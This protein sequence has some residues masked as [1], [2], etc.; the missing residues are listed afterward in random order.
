MSVGTRISFFFV[1]LAAVVLQLTGCSLDNVGTVRDQPNKISPYDVDFD[2][3]SFSYNREKSQD[4][5]NPEEEQ[6]LNDAQSAYDGGL[7]TL[8]REKWSRL[9]DDYPTSFYVPF[10]ELKIADSYFLGGDHAQAVSSY[11]EFIN[12]HPGHEAIPYVQLQIGRAYRAQYSGAKRDITPIKN[13]LK[14]L[15]VLT[16]NFPQSEYAAEGWRLTVECRELIAQFEFEVAL[17]YERRDKTESARARFSDLL[18]NYGDTNVV[19][20]NYDVISRHFDREPD[21]VA[22][23]DK[24]I[25]K[26]AS[27]SPPSAPNILL[28]LNQ[29]ETPDPTAGNRAAR[30]SLRTP[31]TRL[32]GGAA[33]V[34]PTE[35]IINLTCGESSSTQFVSVIPSNTQS[36]LTVSSTEENS[37]T[38]CPASGGA[39]GNAEKVRQTCDIGQLKFNLETAGSNGCV[40]VSLRSDTEGSKPT[41]ISTTRPNRVVIIFPKT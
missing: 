14:S 12:L 13:A 33:P 1:V 30:A 41:V 36:K 22:A 11:Q 32:S 40:N 20:Q 39:E 29:P 17:F 10:V 8:A 31:P 18:A 7:Y 21:V 9:K 27:F 25:K 37:W 34:T 15:R 19:K 35:S 5:E 3:K 28:A 2:S 16:D 23:I 24:P 6:L 38:I 26:D 4:E